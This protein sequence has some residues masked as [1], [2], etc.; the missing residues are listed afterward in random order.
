MSA[1][2]REQE[3]REQKRKLDAVSIAFYTFLVVYGVVALTIFVL[4]K[5]YVG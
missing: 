2:Q 1:V 5:V 3:G 4:Y